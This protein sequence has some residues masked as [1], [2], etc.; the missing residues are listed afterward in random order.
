MQ[1]SHTS[2][3]LKGHT[4]LAIETAIPTLAFTSTVGNAAGRSVGSV[5]ELS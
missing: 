1:V 3:R 5:V 2:A 4:L